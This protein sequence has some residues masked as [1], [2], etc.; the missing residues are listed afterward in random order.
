MWSYYGSKNKLVK[1]YPAPKFKTIIEPFAGSAWYSLK[2]PDHDVILCEKYK[3]VY[4][5]WKWLITEATT[6]EILKYVDFTVGQ[7][8][9]NLPIREEHKNLI[10]FCLNRGSVSPKRIV[11]KWSCQVAS[12]P[13]WAST[14][15]FALN[16]VAKLLPKIKHWK[17]IYG[18]YSELPN[19][20]ATWFI[21]PPYQNGGQHYIVNDI[22]YDDLAKY[23][24]TRQGQVIVC[25]RTNANWLDFKPLISVY[26]QRHNTQE[27]IFC[28]DNTSTNKGSI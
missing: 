5:I 26:G 8:I 6:Q 21:D 27:G 25:E 19:Q 14:T 23:C 2:Y 10:G 18:S 3:V 28:F 24:K 16:R 17:V 12:K 20:E 1:Y 22:N 15:N 9:S 7:N 13:D 11:Q 4:D